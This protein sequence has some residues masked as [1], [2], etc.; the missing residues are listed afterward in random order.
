MRT[1][2]LL[3]FYSD[4]SSQYLLINSPGLPVAEDSYLLDRAGYGCTTVRPSLLAAVTQHL[5]ERYCLQGL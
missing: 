5:T 2:K 4:W 1:I 3:I